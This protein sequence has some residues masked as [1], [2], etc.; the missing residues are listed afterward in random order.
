MQQLYRLPVYRKHLAQRSDLQEVMIGYSDSN[1]ESG[2]LQSAWALYGAQRDLVETGRKAGVRTQMFHGR[3]GTVGRGGGPANRAILAQPSGT[4]NG[5][6][7]VTEQG[8]VIADRYGHDAI[9]ERHLEQIL[10]AV[11]L[12]GFPERADPEDPTWPALLDQ[13]AVS[14]SRHYRA[15]VY[16]TPEFLTYFTQATPIEEIAQFK[17]GSRPTRRGKSD[18]IDD[19][20]AI[21]FVFS[22]MQSRHT[23]P[24]WY[25]LGSAVG[26]FLQAHPG[27][28]P[29]LQ[30]M[31]RRWPFWRSLIDNVQMILAKADMTIARLYADLVE[32]Q[33]MAG[34]MYDRI[35]AEYRRT[36]TCITKITGQKT[37][38]EPMPILQHSIQRRNPYV[39][40]LS[41]LQLVILKRLRSGAGDEPREELLDGVLES[42][43]GI[44]SGLKNTG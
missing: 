25:G 38:L 26:E 30:E 1:K 21:P 29:T 40:A 43:G 37:L 4:V 14:A 10:H 31:Y 19:L 8:E 6:L 42:M 41:F 24:G 16:E 13:L 22:W 15:L 27:E 39:D 7:R 18:R 9:A 23:L 35:A 33:E 32:D 2:F 34:R 44:A 5:R 11:L 36:V 20:R 17:I 28:L 3:G 12:A